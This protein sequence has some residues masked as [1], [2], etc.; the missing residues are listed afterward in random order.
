MSVYQPSQSKSEKAVSR[1]DHRRLMKTNSRLTFLR[2]PPTALEDYPL[3]RTLTFYVSP[4]ASE[5]TS[6]FVSFVVSDRGANTLVKHSLLP[7]SL[8]FWHRPYEHV[9]KSQQQQKPRIPIWEKR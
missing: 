3:V 9:A 1:N 6:E 7:S 5:T 8:S 2:W 4:Y